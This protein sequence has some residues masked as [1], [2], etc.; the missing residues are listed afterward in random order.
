L[1]LPVLAALCGATLVSS[2]YVQ[3][4][5]DLQSVPQTDRHGL[6]AHETHAAASVV[7]QFRTTAAAWLWVRTDLY[8]HGGVELRPM[9]KNERAHGKSSSDAANQ[10]EEHFH[11]QG[12]ITTVVPSAD[13]DHR[14]LLGD[15]ERAT[16]TYRSMKQH[17]HADPTSAL[18]L[19]RLMTWVD[20]NF[21]PGWVVG[22][23]LIAN[24]KDASAVPKAFA[25]L[26]DGLDQNPGNIPILSEL[27]RLALS[28]K[29]S[30][31]QAIPYLEA[32][33]ASAKKGLSDSEE[34]LEAATV[35]YRLLA[36]AYR[37][38]EQFGSM[39]EV[40][41]EGIEL[42]PNDVPLAHMAVPAPLMLPKS[43]WREWYI[44]SAR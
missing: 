42:F 5:P 31:Q 26:L 1:K 29:H 30:A 40:A 38:E 28:K 39:R 27:G 21:I 43:R 37:E 11:E 41:R 3:R 36:L 17:E 22:G 13:E 18:P 10:E 25:Y 6:E 32:A 44:W 24:G 19:F 15:L 34:V 4:I 9:T 16:T 8:V 7:G 2:S 14:G 23:D 33:R 20:P 35:A 12:G